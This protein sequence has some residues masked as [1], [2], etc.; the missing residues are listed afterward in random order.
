MEKHPTKVRVFE[1]FATGSF[2]SGA[3]IDAQSDHPIVELL[4]ETKRLD[5]DADRYV[6]SSAIFVYRNRPLAEAMRQFYM[7]RTRELRQMS[8]DEM[9]AV[10]Y[11]FLYFAYGANMAE[12]IIAKRAPSA[13]AVDVGRLEN[14][15]LSFTT[16]GPHLL[17]R[18]ASIKRMKGKAVWGVVYALNHEDRASL[19]TV[20]RVAYEPQNI[21]VRL[22]D[23]GRAV[24]AFTYLARPELES[25][26]TPDKAYVQ[27][28]MSVA[29]DR[30]IEQLAADLQPYL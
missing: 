11:D 8:P 1:D 24:S 4:F 15:E 12:D 25:P 7:G 29:M 30:R 5:L 20:E 10:G 14:W 22:R 16:T 23:S 27:R 9:R 26:G 19:D 18:G 3:V 28:M 21:E 2:L 6:V 17:G 13:Q